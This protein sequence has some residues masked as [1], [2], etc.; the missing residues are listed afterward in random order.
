[1]DIKRTGLILRPNPSRVVFRPFEP[2]NT[3][4]VSRIIARVMALPET[5]VDAL[6]EGVMHEFRSRHQKIREFFQLR[7]DQVKGYLLTDQ[8]VSNN[9][10]LLIGSYFTQEYSLESAALFNPS[11]VW[12]PDQS[13]LPQGTRRFILSLRATGEGHISS[14]TFR[15]GTIDADMHIRIE[16]PTRFVTAPEVVPNARYDK[17]LFHRKLFELNLATKFA[18]TI[19]AELGETFTMGQLERS[20]EVAQRRYRIEYRDNKQ[21]A[22]GML[23]LARSNYEITY[24]T[25]CPLSGAS[26]FPRHR[27]RATA[28]RMRVLSSFTTTAP[29]VTTRPTLPMTAGWSF[30]NSWKPRIFC[31]FGCAPSMGRKCGTR[32]WPCSRGRSAAASPCFRA[33]TMKTST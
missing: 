5:E 33:R 10:Q 27:P 7:F 25:D 29:S 23:A 14:I 30:H 2:T 32:A 19:L 11:M 1:M 16:P 9:R 28:S 26:S 4:R 18:E 22:Q 12:H 13:G 21:T 24:Q 20:I 17:A 8:S 31:F 3:D 15:C 6:L